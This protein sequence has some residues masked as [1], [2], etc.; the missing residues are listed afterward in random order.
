MQ[1]KQKQLSNYPVW[2]DGTNINE[3]LLQSRPIQMVLWTIPSVRTYRKNG[4]INLVRMYVVI[5]CKLHIIY[6]SGWLSK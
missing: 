3:R 4:Q 1:K 2:F 5:Q 6:F